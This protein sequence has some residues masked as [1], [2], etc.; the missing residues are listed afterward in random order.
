MDRVIPNI[1][2]EQ[3]IDI[4]YLFAESVGKGESIESIESESDS[5]L[6]PEAKEILSDAFDIVKSGVE[7]ATAKSLYEKYYVNVPLYVK[8]NFPVPRY[9][10]ESPQEI[11]FDITTSDDRGLRRLHSQFNAFLSRA[12]WLVAAQTNVVNELSSIHKSN[13]E[14]I[15]LSVDPFYRDEGKTPKEKR[16]SVIEAEVNSHD[17][18]ISS[19]RDLE[20]A[21]KDLQYLKSLRE[22]YDNNCNRLSREATMRENE[23][24]HSGGI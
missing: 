2:R 6:L 24:Q 19:K 15:L 11:P 8:E 5:V 3:A 14:K 1:N 16:S 17:L 18:V 10:E 21:I 7:N 20:E 22:I 12:S 23:R 9:L 4:I 13:C